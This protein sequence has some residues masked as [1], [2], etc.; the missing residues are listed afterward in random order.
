MITQYFIN[1]TND[2]FFFF[3]LST[4]LFFLIKLLKVNTTL[5]REVLIA[6]Y[7]K[8]ELN[9]TGYFQ[10]FGPKSK[11]KRSNRTLQH[12]QVQINKML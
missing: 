3:I 7:T 1:T 4:R 10:K 11:K 6:W 9:T 5:H 2:F 8:A 12:T